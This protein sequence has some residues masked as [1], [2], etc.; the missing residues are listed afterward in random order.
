P[1]F[2]ESDP[3]SIEDY[4]EQC[5]TI[6]DR[7]GITSETDKKKTYV[8]YL[9]TTGAR[10]AW[11]GLAS[12]TD[13]QKKASDFER[14]ILSYFPEVSKRKEGTVAA[15]N[16]LCKINKGIRME[17]EGDL[18]RFGLSFKGLY[19][20]LSQEP[21]VITNKEACDKYVGVLNGSF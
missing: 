2:D 17:Q 7:G 9:N 19:A 6:N 12:Y 16:R 21:P 4:L 13:S 5:R 3:A 10:D 11:M 1:T 18:K 8:K 15:L 14:E 20:K